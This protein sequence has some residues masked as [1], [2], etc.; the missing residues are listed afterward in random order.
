[1]TQEWY[2]AFSQLL[3]TQFKGQDAIKKAEVKRVQGHS[4]T[5]YPYMYICVGELLFNI[6][7]VTLRA[8]ST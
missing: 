6:Y 3:F 8:L 5:T 4:Y 2:L 7:I 1:M